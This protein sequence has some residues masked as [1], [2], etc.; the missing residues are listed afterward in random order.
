MEHDRHWYE[1]RSDKYNKN[2]TREL[3]QEVG[4]MTSYALQ[5]AAIPQ[6]GETI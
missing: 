1:A 4:M 2:K 5:S 6:W 3:K